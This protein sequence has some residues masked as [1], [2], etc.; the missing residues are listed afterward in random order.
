MNGLKKRIFSILPLALPVA[1][2]AAEAPKPAAQ[3]NILWLTAEDANVTCFGCYGNQVGGATTPNIDKLA[4]EGFLYR[5]AF[6][7]APVCAASRSSW[8]TGIHSLS[9]GTYN[10]RSSYPIPHDQIEYYPDALRRAGYFCS[11]H[12]K[13]DYN[14]SGRS[15]RDCWDSDEEYGWRKRA[16]GQPFFC[17]IN[18]M[19]SHESRAMGSVEGT[20]H[21]P[22]KVVLQQYHPDVSTIRK[23]YALYEDA[24]ENMDKRV[25]MALAALKEA[26]LE[27]DTIVIF[28]TDHGGVL[29]FSKHYATEA[30]LHSPFI[31]RIPEKFKQLWPADKPGTVVDRLVS[32]VDMPKTWLSMAQA[33]IPDNMQGKIIL[34][35]QTEP[36]PEYVFAYR[37]RMDERYDEVRVVRDK[38]FIYIKNYQ[39]YVRWG[40]FNKYPARLA[41]WKAWENHFKAGKC[42]EITGR[43]W[44]TKPWVEELYDCQTDPDCVK[45][46]SEQP[47]FQPVLTRMR[48]ALTEWQL[49][50]HDA[51][52]LPESEM[53]RRA[54]VNKTTIYQMVRDPKL[55]NLSAYLTAADVALAEGAANLPQ[56]TGYLSDPDSCLRYWGACGMVMA[57]KLDAVAKAALKKCLTDESHDVRAMA[58]WALIKAGD[59]AEGQ[60]C[61]IEMIQQNSLASCRVLNVIDWM[62]VNKAP[63]MPAIEAMPKGAGGKKVSD[64][65]SPKYSNAMREVL[66]ALDQSTGPKKEKLD[67]KRGVIA[68]D[69]EFIKNRELNPNAV[70]D[71]AA[72]E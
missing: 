65:V 27:D 25:G 69:E 51:G 31:I 56:L 34:G 23:N 8:I 29:P 38:R 17:V 43:F 36:E 40:Q 66:L 60:A 4:A 1:L 59:E 14:I 20:R 47:E 49:K 6:A 7:T 39:P 24:V 13:R 54:Q 9:T 46:L 68:K 37:G 57:D 50:I 16:P 19:E 62:G 67:K 22:S 11:N 12:V 70:D 28:C 10:M 2:S 52:L 48:S 15:D 44:K 30:G 21:D 18:F 3:P 42:N 61:L 5:N 41:A 53:L 55:Y 63:Y 35:P 45:N 58:A 32:F 33:K 26:G 72:E 64:R 71:T